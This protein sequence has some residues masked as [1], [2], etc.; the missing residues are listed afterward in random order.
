MSESTRRDFIKTSSAVVAGAA[1]L[2]LHATT[3]KKQRVALVGTGVRGL[4]MW[5]PELL[6]EEGHKVEM[7]GMC[8]I[9]S[10]RLEVARKH[11]KSTA[12]VE[13]PVYTDFDRMIH[14]TK[15]E[16]IIVTSVDSVHHT[17][18]VRA[19][20]LGCDVITE[21]PMTTDP[22]KLKEI[23]EAQK[24]TGREITVTF[25]YR[26]SPHRRVMKEILES[27][28]L[29]E[30]TSLDF[31][32]YLD[33]QHGAAYFRRW[34]RLLEKGGS[35]WVHKA[36]H[37]FDLVN[38]WLEARPVSV[39]A[40]GELRKYGSSGPYRS[41][42]K[43]CRGCSHRDVCPF[44]WDI[45]ENEFYMDL[46]V[47]CES[48]DGYTRDGCVFREDVNI[49]DTMTATVKYDNDVSMSYSLN[50]FMPYE[51]YRIGF[52][53]TRGRLEHRNF[54]RQPW[55]TEPQD[56]IVVIK[57]FGH[58]EVITVPHGVG[59]HGGGDKRLLDMIFTPGMPDPYKQT[60]DH[61]A[62][63]YAVLPGFAAVR[64]IDERRMVEISEL[65]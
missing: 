9:N 26:F 37:H 18:I 56:E 12:G 49:W 51:G 32:W 21:K 13:V 4:G 50:A 40:Y 30:I 28:E 38:W 47:G 44:F 46:Y 36:S 45:T 39:A 34:H 3:A 10:L 24:R 54:E 64:S 2:P 62:G 6:A 42:T 60:A 61:M 5:G 53:C 29:G 43:T 23:L 57:N 8:D 25:N 63:A 65:L 55:V 17:H 20:E 1:T 7:V 22:A 41:E 14:E 19:M 52:N 59:G 15:P 35:L 33:V 11:M 48:E 27:G 31:H 16:Q 58:R